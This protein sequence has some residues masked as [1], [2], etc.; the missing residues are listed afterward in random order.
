MSES[1]AA[2][3]ASAFLGTHDAVVLQGEFDLLKRPD[4]R[5][6]QIF[7]ALTKTVSENI[8]FRINSLLDV[9]SRRKKEHALKAGAWHW[10]NPKSRSEISQLTILRERLELT[11]MSPEDFIRALLAECR[12]FAS[13]RPKLSRH[14]E[15]RLAELEFGL[16]GASILTDPTASD[17]GLYQEQLLNAAVERNRQDASRLAVDALGAA[18][19]AASAV[20][21]ENRGSGAATNANLMIPLSVRSVEELKARIGPELWG[22]PGA[23]TAAELWDGLP[24]EWRQCLFVI[25]EKGRDA[26]AGFWIPDVRKP[27]T[28][29]PGAPTAYAHQCAQAVF[30]DDLPPF[31]FGD[32]EFEA[33]WRK[34]LTGVSSRSFT[35]KMFVSFPLIVKEEF[36]SQHAVAVVNMNIDTREI[37]RRAYSR[38]WLDRATGAIQHWLSTAWHAIQLA[39]VDIDDRRLIAPSE[40]SRF[41]GQPTEQPFLGSRTIATLPPSRE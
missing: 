36:H 2:G 21:D 17:Y 18:M 38:A 1:S 24:G 30:V 32:A 9:F 23:Q 34:Y 31:H 11:D 12:E 41:C 37:W 25:A 8:P 26:Y 40:L 22:L 14:V 28:A 3:S 6:L 4:T 16:M 33:R 19:V 7:D 35:E 20:L 15:R 13:S 10:L 29:L 5:F 27:G 39:I